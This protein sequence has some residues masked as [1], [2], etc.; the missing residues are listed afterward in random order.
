MFLSQCKIGDNVKIKINGNVAVA[1]I[2]K[3]G[4]KNHLK[5]N[6]GDLGRVLAGYSAKDNNIQVKPV[7]AR[8]RFVPSNTKVIEKIN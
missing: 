4:R 7:G 5:D 8:A 6:F 3:K 2:I 1:R